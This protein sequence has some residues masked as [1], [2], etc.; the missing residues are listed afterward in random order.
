MIRQHDKRGHIF[1]NG[2]KP[3]C[4]YKVLGV[5]WN[6]CNAVCNAVFYMYIPVHKN[7]VVM[8]NLSTDIKLTRTILFWAKFTGTDAAVALA[9]A[10]L[11]KSS[12]NGSDFIDGE[13]A[14]ELLFVG[15]SNISCT[16]EDH[17]A[18]KNHSF[19]FSDNAT[20]DPFVFEA[21]ADF[22]VSFHTLERIR[23]NAN[24]AITK[25]R[26]KRQL[27]VSEERE[28]EVLLIKT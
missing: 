14:R 19:P 27:G 18:S 5:V 6:W 1:S 16:V 17:H 22:H 21:L 24:L 10:L 26:V 4:Y 15:V 2:T 8:R 23:N 7:A 20:V 25:G 12:Q 11:Y 3:S 28:A 13:F 9:V